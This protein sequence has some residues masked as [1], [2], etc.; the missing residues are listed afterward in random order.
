MHTFHIS[1]CSFA[2]LEHFIRLA[3][4]Q[5]YEVLVGDEQVCIR[6]FMGM[7]TLDFRKPLQVSVQCSE[8]ECLEFRQQLGV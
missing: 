6:G 3:L 4:Q 7:F 1:I 5:P 2:Q 8:E